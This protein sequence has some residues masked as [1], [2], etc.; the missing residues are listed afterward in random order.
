V[1]Q[2]SL[3]QYSWTKKAEAVFFL[4]VGKDWLLQPKFQHAH[5]RLQEQR[6]PHC[7]LVSRLTNL[8]GTKLQQVA[9]NRPKV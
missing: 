9:I 4:T 6:K 2:T 3:E 5:Q 1:N 7:C 8:P